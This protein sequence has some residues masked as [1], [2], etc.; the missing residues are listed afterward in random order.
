MITIPLLY[1]C[2]VLYLA[3][4]ALS[5]ARRK[6]N[7]PKPALYLAYPLLGFGYLVDFLSNMVITVLFLDFPR[8]VLVTSRLQRYANGPDG[9]R[10]RLGLWFARNLL[11]PF[12][13]KGYHV[14]VK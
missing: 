6:G 9:W 8:E 5:A 13:P 10:R 11:D 2:W 4:M 12:D 14:K 1:L 3:I 7:L